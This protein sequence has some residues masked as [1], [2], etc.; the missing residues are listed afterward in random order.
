S[1]ERF[2]K[3]Y[4]YSWK[5]RR[6]S[7]DYLFTNAQ[8]SDFSGHLWLRT[9]F[10]VQRFEFREATKF[11]KR[12]GQVND[13][14]G[15]VRCKNHDGRVAFWGAQPSDHSQLLRRINARR[16]FTFFASVTNHGLVTRFNHA[17]LPILG[18]STSCSILSTGSSNL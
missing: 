10:Q 4:A 5:S 15:T 12:N 1:V 17:V 6:S 16:T 14:S 8:S 3:A 9:I 7:L 2:G 13:L 18:R 11:A